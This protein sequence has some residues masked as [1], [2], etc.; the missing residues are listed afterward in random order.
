MGGSDQFT[1]FSAGTVNEL[2]FSVQ[3]TLF[4]PLAPA[5]H[6]LSPARLRGAE[7]KAA[8]VIWIDPD[9]R[10]YPPAARSAG[11][12]L[13]RLYLIHPKPADL[14]WTLSDCLRCREVTAVVAPVGSRLSRVEVRRIQLA[15]EHGNTV[16][17]LLRSRG[18]GDDI[19]A[20]A[21][22]WQVAPLPGDRLTQR[23]SMEFLHGQG[24]HQHPSF[25]MEISRVDQD[26]DQGRNI[27]LAP[28]PVHSSAGV[29]SYASAAQIA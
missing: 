2:L 24:R 13:S 15:A 29:G 22:R 20:A 7:G 1:F 16:A 12:D 28:V 3:Q 26:T 5:L 27:I 6:L 23:W 10:F 4:P 9:R 19:Y 18:K 11:I 8:T 14:V 25:L 21:T 17:V